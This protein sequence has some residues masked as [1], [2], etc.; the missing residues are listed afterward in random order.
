MIHH[1]N[2]RQHSNFHQP[3]HSLTVRKG[4]T[5]QVQRFI[6][7]FLLISKTFLII[8]IDSSQLWKTFYI[9][10]HITL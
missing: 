7:G 9:R 6:M 4:V 1:T 2:T 10:I 8:Q 3:L 5:I